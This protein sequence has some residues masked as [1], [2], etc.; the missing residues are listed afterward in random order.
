M[1]KIIIHI[2]LVCIFI[3]CQEIENN[4]ILAPITNL[5][6]DDSDYILN[7]KFSKGD[8]RRYGVFP[9]RV[10]GK[11]EL[12]NIITLSERGLPITF[13]NGRYDTDMILNKVSNVNFIFKNVIINGSINIT[14]GSNKIKLSGS[15]TVLDKLFIK[16]STNII[17]DTLLVKSDIIKNNFNKK[18]RGVSIYSGSKGIKFK[19]LKIVDTGGNSDDFYTHSAA[20]LQIH[21]WNNNP[22]NIQINTLEINNSARTALYITGMNHKIKKVAITNFGTGSA[23][24]IFGLEDASP[25][26]EKEFSGFWM[27]KCNNCEIDSLSI[28][29]TANSG[30]YSLRLDE[31]LYH[32]PSFINNINFKNEAI[33]MT[34]KD[35]IL[36]NILVKNEY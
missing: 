34:I 10:V 35:D 19:S 11:K 8:S 9:N 2:I 7:K 23:K 21:G 33:G 27:N 18:N 13:I 22:Q 17:F 5:E 28:N 24:N 12:L 36:T 32:K 20:A 14:N 31:G 1:K 6:I 29:N 30:V 26:E 4:E 15:L 3:S 16:E 25:G